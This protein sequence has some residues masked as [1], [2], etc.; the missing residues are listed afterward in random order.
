MLYETRN[1]V[2]TQELFKNPPQEYRGVPFWA[3]NAA[4]DEKEL[5]EQID[6]F[7]EMGFGGFHMHVR[8]GLETEYMGPEFM[9]AVRFCSEYAEEKGMRAWLYDEDRWPSGCAGGQVT[10]EIR[11]RKKYLL[12]SKKKKEDFSLDP[13]EAYELGKPFF[14][15]AFWVCVNEEG[16]LCDFTKTTCMEEGEDIRFFYCMTEMRTE[17]RFNYQTYV[18]TM[19]EEAIHRFIEL[20]HE[21][22]KEAFQERFG[23]T[24]PAIF[25]DEPQ[26]QYAKR[27]TSGFSDEDAILP[28]TLDFADSFQKENGYDI[29]ERLPELF[30]ACEDARAKKTRYDYY[31]HSNIRLHTAYTDQIGKWCQKNGLMMTGHALGEDTLMEMTD[32]GYEVM[33]MY[34]EMGIPGI[35]MLC[36]D[37]VFT[38]P[39]QCRSVVRQYGKEGML[40]EM[41]GVTGW[42]FDFRDHKFQGDWQACLGVTV[43]VPHLAWQTMKGEGKRDYPASIFYQSPWY[44]EYKQLEDHYARVAAALTKGKACVKVGVLHPLESY[45]M[46]KASDA[47]TAGICTEYEERFHTLADWLLRGQIDFD[48]LSQSLLSEESVT[49][50]VPLK[51]GRAEYDILILC[52]CTTLRKEVLTM[53]EEYVQAGGKLLIMGKVPSYCDGIESARAKAFSQRAT[54]I[55]YSKTALLSALKPYRDVEICDKERRPVDNLMYTMRKDEHTSWLFI[56]QMDKPQLKHIVQKQSII[57]RIK[58]CFKPMEYDTIS[59]EQR[60]IPYEIIHGETRVYKDLY[61]SDS[62]LLALCPVDAAEHSTASCEVHQDETVLKTSFDAAYTLSE[63]NVLPLDMAEYRVNGGAW[64]EKEEIMRIDEAVRRELGLPTRRTKVVQPYIIQAVPTP[65]TVELRYVVHSQAE[66]EQVSLAL[67]NADTCEI[68]LNGE[69]ILSDPEGYYVDKYIKTV[70]LGNIRKGENII[71]I[72]MPFGQRTDLELCYLIGNFGTGYCG[73]EQYLCLLPEKLRF[74]SVVQ[75]GMAFYGGNICY[76]TEVVLDKDCDLEVEATCYRGALLKVSLDQ[77]K[78][79]NLTFAPYKAV[80]EQVPAGKHILVYELFGNRYNTFSAL[81]T[82]LADKKRVY[83][84]PDY[85]RSQ[86][87]GWAYE[88]QTRPFGI[89]KAPIVRTKERRND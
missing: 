12:M 88:Y 77:K 82:L 42:D 59:G 2:L 67:E 31:R 14:L 46:E 18:D 64:K 58:G 63:P 89:L 87:D 48:Y 37:K 13:K 36:D 70:Y 27:L 39:I 26:M 53:L 22:Y 49:A 1:S 62:L 10:K 20:T 33:R 79:K 78:T 3:W 52:D 55:P 28:F 72:K 9:D 35:D 84:G 44:Q 81:H 69:Q 61:Q 40:S 21:K 23:K 4:L 57:I 15:G 71:H 29:L 60:A 8:Q 45:W 6:Y 7:Y 50:C 74:G 68:Y 16:I 65:H 32:Q 38:T 43:R 66:F 76:Q 51:V 25:T 11:Y 85:W 47:E 24:I 54:C 73:T 56:A 86:D 5:K 75:Q 80:F 83:I 41:Y 34:K 17:P 19:S 30:F